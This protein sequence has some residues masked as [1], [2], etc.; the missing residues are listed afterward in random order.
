M[1]LLTLR[2]SVELGATLSRA[3]ANIKRLST[4]TTASAVPS[5]ASSGKIARILVAVSPNQ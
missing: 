4:A 2:I 5:T 3:K 1:C